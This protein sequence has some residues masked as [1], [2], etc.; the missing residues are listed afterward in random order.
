[1][2]AGLRSFDRTMPEEHNRVVADHCADLLCCPTATAMRNLEREGLA[3]RARLVG[4]TM[5]DA[6][7]RFGEIAA[8]RSKVLE[9]LGLAPG[10]YTL[11][12]LHRPS[13]VDDPARLR[14]IV[15]GLGALEGRIV[16][17]VHPRSKA[18]LEALGGGPEKN[19]SARLGLIGPASYM[20]MLVLER[21]AKLVVTDSGGVQKEAFFLGVPCITLR[22]STEWVETVASGWNVLAE[23]T[24]D[25]ILSAVAEHAVRPPHPGRDAPGDGSAASRV[26]RELEG[27]C[28]G[29]P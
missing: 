25:G 23:G 24:R 7:L 9:A 26:V 2:E 1:M 10:G 13:N 12:T 6:L 16:W 15:E 21:N 29:R 20:A 18:R 3:G 11:V 8:N 19:G 28:A 14:S 17:P 5:H 4:D 27:L 22:A